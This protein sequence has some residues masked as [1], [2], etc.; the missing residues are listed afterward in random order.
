MEAGREWG[1]KKRGE[2]RKKSSKGRGGQEGS[3][4]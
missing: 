1:R 4:G 3:S 2:K